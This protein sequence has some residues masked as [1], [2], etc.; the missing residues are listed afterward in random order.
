MEA[1]INYHRRMRDVAEKKLR[2]TIGNIVEGTIKNYFEQHPLAPKHDW[3][4]E[5]LAKRMIG[6]LCKADTRRRL[7]T[8]IVNAEK[9]WL[10][11]AGALA[12]FLAEMS[13][14][15][16]EQADGNPTGSE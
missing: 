14:S 3:I 9:A 1:R 6:E 13:E 15:Q 5:S 11:D 16:K 4:R 7:L 10:E 8:L 12:A 2:K